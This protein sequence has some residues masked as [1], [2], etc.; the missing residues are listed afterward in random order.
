MRPAE[1]QMALP[2]DVMIAQELERTRLERGRRKN[3][4]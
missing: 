4:A 3:G 1:Y 2:D